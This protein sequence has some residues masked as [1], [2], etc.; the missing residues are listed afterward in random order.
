MRA[1]ITR[2]RALLGAVGS[3]LSVAVTACGADGEPAAQTQPE[4][5]TLPATPGGTL[6]LGIVGLF[7]ADLN[8]S[9]AFYRRLGLAIPDDVDTSGGAFRLRQPNGQIFFW[10]T[11]AY[12]RRDFP[13]YQPARGDRKVSLEFGFA[14]PED[15]DRMYETLTSAGAGA[16]FTPTQW[17][18]VRFAA[19][20]DPDDNQIGLRYPLV[21]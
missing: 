8:R 1:P 13:D 18:S 21:S 6:G 19:V 9:L 12:T 16:Y 3:A 15:L 10:E 7:V 5:T 17:G 14:S 2:R 4:A 11:F 20:V